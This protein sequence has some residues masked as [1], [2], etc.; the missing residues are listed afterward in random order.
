MAVET[1]GRRRPDRAPG[2]AA[3]PGPGRRRGRGRGRGRAA[4]L[5]TSAALVTASVTAGSAALAADTPKTG[6]GKGGQR[7]TVSASA[8]L[9]PAGES[10]RV[11]GEGYDGTKG[12]YVAFCKDNGDN[13][14][15][16]PCL[17]GA[18]MTG[19][20]G[21]SQWIVPEGDSY[22]GEL[23]T[24]YGPDG[25]FDVRITVKA[26]GDGLDCTRVGCAVVT[27]VD[28]RGSGDRSQDVRIPVAFEGQGPGDGG[29]GVDVPAGTV[30]YRESASFTTAGKPLDVLLHPDSGKLYVG[31]DNLA[32]T[33][34]VN[35]Q[36]LYVLD[37]ANGEVV[38]HIS[39]APGSTGA[40]AGRRVTRIIAPLAGDGVVFHYPLRGI[41][42]A[43]AGD[44]AAR[45]VWLGGATVTG[46]GP[47]TEPATVLVA[48][49]AALSEVETATGTVRRGITLDGGG[50]LG[51]DPAHAA[52]WS[53]GA[54]GG[55]L[56]RVDTGSFT[57]T[58]TA[59][60]PAGYVR[61]VEA[62][63]ATGNVWV[64][65]G[66]SVLVYDR[67][68][69]LLKTVE[70]TDEA[71]GIA[72]DPTTQR[73]F[74]VRQDNGD[75]GSGGD[76][77]G[78]LA[79][80]STTTYEPAAEP[81]A[82][83][84]NHSQLGEATVA[85]TPGGSTVYV[86]SPA[87]GTVT[88]LDRRMSPKV[89]QAPADRSAAPG[90]DVAFTAAAEGAPEPTVRW[91]VSPDGG[92]T[93]TTVEGAVR[94]TYAFTATAAHDGYRYRAEFTNPAG[95][96]RTA[97]VTL[98]VVANGGEDGGGSG[99]AGGSGGGD[100]E[101][102]SGSGGSTGDS[103]GGSSSG[104]GSADGGTSGGA[105]GSVSGSGATSGSGSGSGGTVGGGSADAGSGDGSLASTGVTVLSLAA[106]AALLTGAGWFALRRARRTHSAV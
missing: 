92:Q 105:G 29:D 73:A 33:A 7:L 27:R 46:A 59:E 31:S 82:L 76:N 83:P 97:P 88:K 89:T 93:W 91:Q 78:S 6:L 61:F 20:G 66:N 58:A 71:A 36:G 102:P 3:G 37:P 17:G 14:V 84:G 39:Q 72:F 96:T 52:A 8:H 24:A 106:A 9:D 87:A 94:H 48:Q 35:E 2:A 75:T 40:L 65:S 11:T 68:A 15:P 55:Q 57:V 1:T 90:D 28:H 41:G 53:A 12:V 56:R 64:G 99:G 13:R 45:G 22:E 44:T 98:T 79:V 26:K 38:G 25:T 47:G 23:A 104:S 63:P 101:P 32:D 81:T 100:D 51:V 67:D 85:V 103:A 69:K 77:D 30:S 10:I 95:T 74:V 54:S 19:G 60:L 62:D 42:T 50:V 43:K 5:L 34:D 49:G 16:S 4:A 70:G 86:T 21:A 80:Y 18:D